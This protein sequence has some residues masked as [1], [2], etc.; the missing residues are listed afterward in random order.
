MNTLF[1]FIRQGQEALKPTFLI[2]EQYTQLHFKTESRPLQEIK[3]PD[4]EAHIGLYKKLIDKTEL[5][6]NLSPEIIL[7]LETTSRSAKPSAC[8][9]QIGE[10]TP[11]P[12]PGMSTLEIP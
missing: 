3:Y 7:L 2:L 1:E 8:L 9:C 5:N 6:K 4:L 10:N 12:P 11:P